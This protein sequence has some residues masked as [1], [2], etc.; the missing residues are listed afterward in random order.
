M[1]WTTVRQTTLSL[2]DECHYCIVS[3]ER[4]R[5]LS[6]SPLS[7]ALYSPD[8]K[9]QQ[10]ALK[11]IWE[12]D[13]D[14]SQLEKAIAR[15]N[16]TLD[17]L[18]ECRDMRARDR[19]TLQALLSPLRRIP[20]EVWIKIFPSALQGTAADFSL[21]QVC[22]HWRDF[23]LSS[24]QIFDRVQLDLSDVSVDPRLPSRFMFRYGNRLHGGVMPA[25]IEMCLPDP[26]QY[27]ALEEDSEESDRFLWPLLGRHIDNVVSQPWWATTTHLTIWN[28]SSF[29]W[30]RAFREVYFIGPVLEQLTIWTAKPINHQLSRS[31][32]QHL[33]WTN[34][35]ILSAFAGCFNLRHFVIP[36]GAPMYN[37][38]GMAETIHLTASSAWGGMRVLRC[39]AKS[40]ISCTI[41]YER[42]N[43]G[44]SSLQDQRVGLPKLTHL[45]LE[46]PE[47]D[48]VDML[49][50]IHS[51]ALASLHIGG[52]PK[53]GTL[54]EFIIRVGCTLHTLSIGT[55]EP[56][57][58]DIELIEVLRSI[59]T[60][61]H[62]TY[63]DPSKAITSRHSTPG[64]PISDFVLQALSLPSTSSH[65]LLPILENF[66]VWCLPTQLD[67]LLLMAESRLELSERENNESGT[68]I[69][70]TL[71]VDLQGLEPEDRRVNDDSMMIEEFES[72][73]QKL[74]RRGLTIYRA[75]SPLGHIPSN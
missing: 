74:R 1:D 4:T 56:E 3:P 35:N 48:M 62:F 21:L 15:I 10:Q 65:P 11:C 66:S 25:R 59:P 70:R 29:E 34:C 24:P 12:A 54:H 61:R 37:N 18:K 2:C 52:D 42:D 58:L 14:I 50:A 13:Q 16:R 5:I 19:S 28:Y 49:S 39:H 32:N 36:D 30:E 7:H 43:F 53:W 9:E 17:S 51:P 44:F 23:L 72:R 22:R 75:K 40:L 31:E 47:S 33:I 60:I 6:T 8:E 68:A 63:F 26:W 46:S 41:R 71:V 27:A 73:V 38:G 45:A 64:H 55:S 67:T 20:N 69:L 57:N